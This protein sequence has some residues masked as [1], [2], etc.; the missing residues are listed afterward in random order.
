MD[1]FEHFQSMVELGILQFRRVW[2]E[3]GDLRVEM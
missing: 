1:V 3:S 2:A